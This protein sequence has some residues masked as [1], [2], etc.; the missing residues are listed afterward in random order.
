MMILRSDPSLRWQTPIRIVWRFLIV[1]AR[2]PTLAVV[3][4]DIAG[5]IG[6]GVAHAFIRPQ[7]YALV[8]HASPKPLNEHV[9]SPRTAPVH[10]EIRPLL[11]YSAGE[12]LG[13]EMTALIGVDDPGDAVLFEGSLDDLDCVMRLER[14]G[15]FVREHPA[16]G[17]VVDRRQIRKAVLHRNVCR[18]ERPYLIGARDGDPAQQVWVD[19]M[20][21]GAFAGAG[22]RALRRNIE[23]LH[24]CSNMAATDINSC[25]GKLAF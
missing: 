16:A 14:G 2:V 17:H 9:V 22:L 11:E 10:A 18:I 12:L 6:S 7:V 25:F 5:N 20:P 21:G 15:H 19:L 1:Q 24:E 4:V 8:F 23:P 13:G 3:P